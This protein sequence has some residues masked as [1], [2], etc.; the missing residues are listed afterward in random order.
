MR[1]CAV[2]LMMPKLIFVLS[3]LLPVPVCAEDVKPGI[4]GEPSV[5]ANIQ[6]MDTDRDGMVSVSEIKAHLQKRFGQHYQE[7]LLEK[8]E[9]V[10]KS[11]SCNSSFTRPLLQ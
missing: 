6:A 4:Q 8:M 11:Q 10:A 9:F 1:P 7:S 2:N 5:E 3:L